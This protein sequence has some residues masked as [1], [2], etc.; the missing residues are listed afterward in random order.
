MSTQITQVSPY[1]GRRILDCLILNEPVKKDRWLLLK[2]NQ[3]DFWSYQSPLKEDSSIISI[4]SND[5]LVI[6]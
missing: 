5:R 4:E 2:Y 6:F 1:I 3:I